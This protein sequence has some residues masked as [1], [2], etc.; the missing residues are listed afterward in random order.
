M[1]IDVELLKLRFEILNVSLESLSEET[2]VP[3]SSLRHEAHAK[4]WKQWWPELPSESLPPASPTH[5]EDSPSGPTSTPS[6]LDL[7]ETTTDATT[8]TTETETIFDPNDDDEILSPLEEG[9]QRYIKEST[10][11]LQVFNIAK[12]IHLSHKY[13]SFESALLDKA[14]EL[15][16]TASEAR[17][18]ASL[19]VVL[20]KLA[21]KLTR[22][23]E[24]DADDGG[25]PM[26][27]IRDLSGR[28]KP[29]G[30]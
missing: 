5:T 30:T 2:G 29:L 12:D 6:Y 17:D 13:A 3:V 18:I 11:R 23:L 4:G 16:E 26:V 19:S 28:D 24:L 20:S 27:I 7:A 14:K 22:Q 9:S 8:G 15:V 1:L 21:S 10:L 25:L